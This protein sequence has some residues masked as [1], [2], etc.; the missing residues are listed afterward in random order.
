[1]VG[2]AAVEL[3]RFERERVL[4]KPT[5]NLVAY[6]AV[7]RGRDL[8]SHET[9][10]SNEEAT[11]LFQRAIELDPGY[12]DAYAALAGSYY[13]AVISGWSEF[14]EAELERAETLAKKALSLDPT[15]TRAYHVLAFI[16]VYRRKYDDALIQIDHA[17]EFNPSDANSYAYRAT[18]L[19]WDGK[20]AEA[21]TWIEG[22]LRFDRLNG[23]AAS[24]LCMAKYL[25]RQYTEAV[26]ACDRALSWNAGH[27]VE[28]TTHPMLAAAYAELGRQQDADKERTA[29]LHLWP[30]LDARAFAAQ[31]RTKEA[32]AHILEGLN[33]AGFH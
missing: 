7:L 31:F 20:P 8:F 19:I 6:E 5:S 4:T 30:F 23:L 14:R 13:E 21:L 12:A 17:L 11:E 2:G 26:A 29:T 3:T 25:L 32:Q 15:T 22:A 9:R 24:K 27:N 16:E 33:K 18:I 1:V 10:E 28:M